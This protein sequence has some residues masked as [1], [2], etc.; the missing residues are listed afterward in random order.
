MDGGT[1][2]SYQKHPQEEEMQK[3]KMVV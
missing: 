2:G 3:D 1:G